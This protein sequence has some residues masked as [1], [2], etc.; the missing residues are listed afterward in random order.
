MTENIIKLETP[1]QIEDELNDCLTEAITLADLLLN[2]SKDVDPIDPE[3]V[4]YAGHMIGARL[5][6]AK[7]LLGD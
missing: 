5:R 3:T 4:A 7:E 2:G 1:V 6:R